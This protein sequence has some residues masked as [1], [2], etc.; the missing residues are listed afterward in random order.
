MPVS[1]V[2]CGLM[3]T[4][5][6]DNGMVDRVYA[7]A[8]GTQGVVPGTTAYAR[9]MAQVH[10]SRGRPSA[11]VL[12]AMFPDS[13][14]RAQAARLALERSCYDAVGRMGAT[15][16]PGAAAALGELA[17]AGIRICLL[18]AFSRRLINLVVDT[19]G[20]WDRVALVL[21]ADEV[22][23][24]LPWPDLMLSAMLKLG[25]EDVRETAVAH[26]TE[27]GILSGCRAGAGIVAGVLT[28]A[29]SGDRHRRAGATHLVPSIAHLPDLLSASG[30]RPLLEP[31][32]VPAAG[33]RPMSRA[34]TQSREAG[35]PEAG[36]L[37]PRR[38]PR[39]DEAPHPAPIT[40][41]R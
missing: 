27:N 15:P 24:G 9:C 32:P 6:S 16:A 14:A 12:Q 7:E 33:S 21:S 20:W 3:G 22:R 17:G 36:E 1:L 30:Q 34:L 40:D 41:H 35:T 39:C 8:I 10:Q 4:V 23:K 37:P 26:D 28:G 31:P 5:V 25:V 18:T 38:A 11:D 13:L 29:H 2:C 19:L